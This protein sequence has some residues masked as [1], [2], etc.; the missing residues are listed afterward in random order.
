MEIVNA[1]LAHCCQLTIYFSYLLQHSYLFRVLKV[2][3][4]Y[5]Y[6]TLCLICLCF[7]TIFCY[8]YQWPIILISSLIFALV[9]LLDSV[10]WALQALYGYDRFAFSVMTPIVLTQIYMRYYTCIGCWVV[11]GWILVMF[12]YRVMDW[13]RWLHWWYFQA[14]VWYGGN[15]QASF[16]LDRVAFTV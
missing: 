12:L 9:H 5:K 1:P 15:R 6:F 16:A 14:V 3:F 2:F 11:L 8:A 13:R 7:C 10:F 4:L